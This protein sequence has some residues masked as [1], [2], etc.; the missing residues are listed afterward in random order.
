[1][2]YDSE[3]SAIEVEQAIRA[4]MGEINAMNENAMPP[5]PPPPPQESKLENN[6]PIGWTVNTEVPTDSPVISWSS[7]NCLYSVKNPANYGS[8]LLKLAVFHNGHP[9]HSCGLYLEEADETYKRLNDLLTMLGNM[10][11]DH[12]TG[13]PK[14]DGI[15]RTVTPLPAWR[16]IHDYTTEGGKHKT[17]G[18]CT[19]GEKQKGGK[20]K[21]SADY[22]TGDGGKQKGGKRKVSA[23]YTTD[24]GKQK[25]GKRKAN[26]D[27]KTR[28]GG[29]QKGGK[30]KKSRVT[31]N[32][33]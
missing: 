31:P 11:V 33:Q 1:M 7:G 29:E 25:G 17:S 20:R 30:R 15:T 8:V 3:S 27:C 6:V 23:D 22:T 32:N 16:M 9:T 4:L 19:T 5:P 24:G 13:V 2:S 21:A 26:N 14:V 12:N 28:D 10:W 18:D